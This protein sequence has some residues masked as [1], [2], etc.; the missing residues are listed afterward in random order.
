M[1]SLVVN[2]SELTSSK[3]LPNAVWSEIHSVFG[4]I[5][6][7]IVAK[8]RMIVDNPPSKGPLCVCVCVCVYVRGC[9]C[10]SGRYFDCRSGISTEERQSR[11]SLLTRRAHRN[12]QYAVDVT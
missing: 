7:D 11:F 10:V 2:N 4:D 9:M 8:A 5:P 3:Y 6:V 12:G 1:N